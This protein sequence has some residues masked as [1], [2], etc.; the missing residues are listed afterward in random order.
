M[1]DR[2]S[3]RIFAP[4]RAV[5]LLPG[6]QL[7]LIGTEEQITAAQDLIH[8]K[9][10]HETL[11]HDDRY[12]LESLDIK[13]DS[14]YANRSIRDVGFGEQYGGLI[15]GIDRG[16]ERIL[17]PESNVV[18]APGDL[19]WIFGQQEKIKE[20]RKAGPKPT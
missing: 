11:P 2:G 16:G 4:G 10:P 17:N 13:A 20:L 6:D 12:T 18:L 5:R 15:V 1:I 19:V 8:P 7:H 3:R 9:V 14:I